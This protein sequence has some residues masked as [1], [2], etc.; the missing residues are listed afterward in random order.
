MPGPDPLLHS[1]PEP[2]TAPT[3]AGTSYP[4]GW[5]RRAVTGPGR[6][7]DL[8]GRSTLAWLQTAR[9]ILA[10]TLITFGSAVRHG[11]RASRAVR[12]LIRHQIWQAGIRLLPLTGFIA[13]SLGVVVIGQTIALLDRLGAEAFVGTIMVSAIVRELGPLTVAMLVLTRVGAAHVIELG[14][15]RALGELEA[16]ESLGIDPLHYLVVPR[17]IGMATAAFALTVYLLLITLTA[18]YLFAFVQNV[19]LTPGAY[20][21]QLSLALGWGDFPLL[22][23]K[24]LGFG[25]LIG[26]TTCYHGLARPL[27]LEQLAQVTSR[28][29]VHGVAGCVLFD[30]L[31]IGGSLLLRWNP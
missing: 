5:F 8:L 1:P 16:F 15:T 4:S 28:A 11:F 27:Q 13:F 9:A 2:G 6:S 18:G 21:R 30:V 20:V 7:V 31:L 3:R 10:F 14:T 22:V 29:L 26:A 17:I 12:P 24:S 25:A 19:A 23:F